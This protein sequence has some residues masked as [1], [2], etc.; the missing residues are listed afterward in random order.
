MPAKRATNLRNALIH[1]IL[2]NCLR[3]LRGMNHPLNSHRHLWFRLPGLLTVFVAG[4]AAGARAADAPQTF[5]SANYGYS[6]QFPANW[7]KISDTN[8][9]KSAERAL[10]PEA[11]R[12]VI[13]GAAFQRSAEVAD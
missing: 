13:W 3:I 11:R 8:L 9:R 10:N 12:S 4:L 7:H 6:V 2:L 5:S 1:S